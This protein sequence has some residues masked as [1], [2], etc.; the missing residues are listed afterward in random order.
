MRPLGLFC[1]MLLSICSTG[2][3]AVDAVASPAPT[4]SCVKLAP[5]LIAPI[6]LAQAD[7]QK[8]PARPTIDPDLYR[9]LGKGDVKI[10][11]NALTRSDVKGQQ[12]KR[13]A[14]FRRSSRLPAERLAVM[15]QDVTAILARTH[16]DEMLGRLQG[17]PDVDKDALAWGQNMAKAFDFCFE[18]R[19]EQFGGNPAFQESVAEVLN[20]RNILEDLVLGNVMPDVVE[21]GVPP[22]PETP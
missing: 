4:Q 6:L 20:N 9:P 1:I 5:A 3:L 13:I 15:M 8:S 18:G 21:G 10:L 12:G 19:Y 16:L 2:L 17:A 22:G 7:M 11:I 14:A